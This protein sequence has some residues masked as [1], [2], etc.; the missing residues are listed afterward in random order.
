MAGKSKQ[1]CIATEGAT[2]DGR[3]IERTWLEQMATNYDPKRYGAR[4]NMEHIK[5]Y[6]PD[7]PFKRYGDVLSL[8]TKEGDDGKLRLYAVID[9]TDDLIVMTK[10]RQKVY[11]SIEV[12]PKFADSGE[13]YLVGLA[14]TDDPASLGTEMLQFSASAKASPLTK[15]KTDPDN[16]F[17]EAIEFTLE[18]EE[19]NSAQTLLEGFSAKIK[20]MFSS[21][22]KATDAD[23]AELRSAIEVIAET[24]QQLL[25]Q[26]AT[27]P[28]A[29]SLKPLQ[30]KLDQLSADHDELVQ[31]LSREP[32]RQP[33]ER[34]PGGSAGETLTD[35]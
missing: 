23:T 8:S 20:N 13:A 15:R 21:A 5:G 22:R 24:Q 4:V 32:Q 25:Q 31:K 30:D 1:F 2:T 35:C 19:E 17:S 3:V 16:L 12:N 18:L 29:P 6:T 33:R 14:V 9:P 34:T 11:T 26:F 7:S 27:L 10:A 28:Q